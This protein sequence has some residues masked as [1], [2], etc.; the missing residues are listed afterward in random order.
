MFD[1]T[2]GVP[3]SAY[4]AS[5]WTA[6]LLFPGAAGE[7]HQVAIVGLR[8]LRDATARLKDDVTGSETG[9]CVLM[10]NA[11][12]LTP[13]T[14]L[15]FFYPVAALVACVA[16]FVASGALLLCVRGSQADRPS[17][18]AQEADAP[19]PEAAATYVR[20][21]AAGMLAILAVAGSAAASGTADIASYRITGA[22]VT[23]VCPLTVGGSF[24]AKTR[25]VRGDVGT[26]ADQPG[27]IEGALHVNLQSLETGIGVR[28]RHMRENYL[29]VQKGPDFATAT[30]EQIRVE[31]LQGST[32][33]KGVL[34]LHGEKRE[35]SG[36]AEI[37]EQDGRLRVQAQFP[38]KV[39]EFAIPKPSYLGVGVRDEVQ[40]KV[41]LTVMAGPVAQTASAR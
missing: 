39:S 26:R 27:A 1:V 36:T 14:V 25:E 21:A 7:H 16:A 11:L 9:L 8:Q 20:G 4:D 32:T 29:E 40:V 17:P 3:A 22:E 37:K 30:L 33:L 5:S 2:T 34:S 13:L 24:E 10:A 41:N 35:I 6:R 38:V 31:R 28:D 15:A 18:V 12:L 23:I 19:N